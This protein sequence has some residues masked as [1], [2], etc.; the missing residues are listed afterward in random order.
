[1][2]ARGRHHVGDPD[3]LATAL[4]RPAE[5][6]SA[7]E[8]VVV[9]MKARAGDRIRETILTWP[10][11]SAHPHRF[12]GTEYRVGRIELDHV[13]GDL[14]A[15]LPFPKRIRDELVRTGDALPHHVLPD[16]GW[17]S[18]WIESD[19]DVDRAVE[20]FRMNY[21]RVMA[22]LCCAAVRDLTLSCSSNIPR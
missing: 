5:N 20:L 16:S 19:A 17:V 3:A 12:G 7:L 22:R 21:D 8:D 1:V 15:D 2:G 9:D 4:I 18:Y 10:Q 11:V 14:L 13:H 6:D